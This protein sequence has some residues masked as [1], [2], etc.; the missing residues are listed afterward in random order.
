MCP[1]PRAGVDGLA[2]SPL[3]D[4]EFVAPDFL[5]LPT[6]VRTQAEA[7]AALRIAD[8]LLTLLSSQNKVFV[9]LLLLL[10][11]SVLRA[12]LIELTVLLLRFLTSDRSFYPPAFFLFLLALR[13]SR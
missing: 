12:S 8:E 3:K 13:A 1:R 4:P 2:G 11:P 5:Q 6:S 7:M 10:A 9:P